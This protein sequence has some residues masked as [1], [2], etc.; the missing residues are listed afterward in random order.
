M[1]PG[2]SDSPTPFS[3]STSTTYTPMGVYY[4]VGGGVGVMVNI[5]TMFKKR[6]APIDYQQKT[7]ATMTLFLHSAPSVDLKVMSATRQRISTAS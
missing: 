1:M 7:V 3:G 6:N 4:G 5:A 2:T